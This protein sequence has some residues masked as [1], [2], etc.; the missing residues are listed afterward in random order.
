MAE[1]ERQMGLPGFWDVPERT[2]KVVAELKGLRAVLTPVAKITTQV[3]E[4]EVLFELAVAEASEETIAEA[5]A[6]VKTV[7]LDLDRL[8]LRTLLSGPHDAGNC[9]FSIH[10]GAGGTESCDWAEML[11]RM[12][13][14]YFERGGYAFEEI[15]RVDG[16]EAGVRSVTLKV[17]GSYAYGYL[18]CERGV[19]RLVR[20]SPYDAQSRRHTSFA[21]VD[22]LPELEDVEVTIDWD[23]EI[24]E[25]VFRASGAGG[26]H[27]NKTSSAIRLT[28]LPTGVAVQC[29]NQRS[30][31]QNRAQARMMLAAK[32]YQLEVAKRDAEMA[33]VYGDKGEI[34]FGSQI[35][36]YVLYPYQL[37]RDERTELKLTQ[38]DR[39]LDGEIQELI[40]S[41]LR[42]RLA[43]R[44]V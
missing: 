30:Q 28:H 25:D 23:K 11:L 14:R 37:V 3:D 2:Q 1:L 12:Y 40:D 10:A 36:S 32:L 13:L 9:F 43:N 20:I 27:V 19:H 18:S 39:V 35:R 6:E 29:Q 42:H 24:R 15:D 16:E 7:G 26:Q 17:S 5:H 8:E 31:H 41:V 44:K 33:K 4:L 38:T 21:S 34:A 22:V